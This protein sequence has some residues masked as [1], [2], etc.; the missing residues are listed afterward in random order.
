MRSEGVS[1]LRYIPTQF[2]VDQKDVKGY[3]SLDEFD[4]VSTPWYLHQQNI[5][6]VMN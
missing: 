4:N 5:E 6:A 2:G 1:S 3:S